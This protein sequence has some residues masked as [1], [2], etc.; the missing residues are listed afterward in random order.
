MNV[1][2]TVV[3]IPMP[4]W[5]N[6]LSDVNECNLL[7]TP[8]AQ[9]CISCT[10]VQSAKCNLT[11]FIFFLDVRTS[12]P[13]SEC[14]LEASVVV[15]APTKTK[16]SS[17]W[18]CSRLVVNHESSSTLDPAAKTMATMDSLLIMENKVIEMLQFHCG[19]QRR[20]NTEAVQGSIPS[21]EHCCK[22]SQE[23]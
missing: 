3:I 20:A 7:G 13:T 18:S 14:F 19:T 9:R 17:V 21:R 11:D 4:A 23:L 8:V 2:L 16:Y 12:S 1:Q 5:A 10:H 15:V 6:E 22:L